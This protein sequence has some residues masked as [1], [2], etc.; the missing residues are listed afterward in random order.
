[1]LERRTV[2]RIGLLAGL[3]L[4]GPRS[5]A[6]AAGPTVRVVSDYPARENKVLFEVVLDKPSARTTYL[7][8]S[9]VDAHSRLADRGRGLMETG[10][11]RFKGRASLQ[12]F[13]GV[14]GSLVVE[15]RQEGGAL[16]RFSRDLCVKYVFPAENYGLFL[17]RGTRDVRWLV[18][19]ESY[20][21]ALKPGMFAEDGLVLERYGKPLPTSTQ[22][23]GEPRPDREALLS[24]ESERLIRLRAKAG[25]P[26]AY[27]FAETHTEAD[28][29][30]D[31]AGPDLGSFRRWLWKEYGSLP[32]LNF[33]W[34]SDFR[35]W[36]QV[37]GFPGSTQ[38]E[39]AN[40]VPAADRLKWS[41]WSRRERRTHL[42]S[43]LRKCDPDGK[44]ATRVRPWASGY[45]DGKSG[46]EPF[47]EVILTPLGLFPQ[48]L[49]RSRAPDYRV[50]EI[51]GAAGATDV[52][53]AM[54]RGLLA[55]HRGVLFRKG[56]D[57]LNPGGRL[58]DMGRAALAQSLRFQE[59]FY[60]LLVGSERRKAHIAIH[61]SRASA[62]AARRMDIEQ[63]Y[64]ASVA[65]W[66][67]LIRKSGMSFDRVDAM[68][69][70]G[71]RLRRQGYRILI[72][73]Q[74]VALSATEALEIRK[75]VRDGGAVVGDLRVGILNDRCRRMR[76]GLL[77]DVFGIERRPEGGVRNVTKGIELGGG[78]AEGGLSVGCFGTYDSSVTPT[79]AT[80]RGEVDGAAPAFLTNE[81][82]RGKTVYLN[83]ARKADHDP[84]RAW[85]PRSRE[86]GVLVD[87][88]RRLG[89]APEYRVLS[90]GRDVWGVEM[91]V[92]SSGSDR[93]IAMTTDASTDVEDAG[94]TLPDDFWCYDLVAGVLLGRRR[95]IALKSLDADN[96]VHFVALLANRGGKPRVSAGGRVRIGERVSY[97]ATPPHGA[98]RRVYR[99][100]VFD[101]AGRAR[102]V[103]GR[104]VCCRQ[105]AAEGSFHSA[106]NDMPGV[107]RIVARDVVTG[108]SAEAEMQFKVP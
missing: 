72:L 9:L 87:W 102:K 93:Y 86:A 57:A 70:E 101:P 19:Y 58:T 65:G 43:R 90:Q 20:A 24:P 64:G 75:F 81:F 29:F 68:E 14:R 5:P 22:N 11:A 48:G 80:A 71:G 53:L 79:T 21:G 12:R 60:E 8:W 77:D 18:D 88:L 40:L 49:R 45:L 95:D 35:D 82:G 85:P 33:Q 92:F 47:P 15:V 89:A 44:L 31:I 69:I 106:L 16:S 36:R 67:Q 6:S 100:E 97:R 91:D 38:V 66:T 56:R 10:E 13:L 4:A 26:V 78:I 103:Y 94:L 23:D 51:V 50:T 108:Q 25:T 42:Q 84:H 76:Y 99:V 59:G 98:H 27:W 32:R 62:I 107:W 61:C 37:K 3:L 17:V 28:R 54:W 1:M 46:S 96:G 30:H 2:W 104:T 34:G 39:A 83:V 7:A 73:P 41:A 55:G 74:S 52:G 105:T 63:S